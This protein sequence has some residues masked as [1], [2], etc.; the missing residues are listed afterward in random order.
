[1]AQI[2]FDT[3]VSS[4][5]KT[6]RVP[7]LI[8]VYV[9]LC[10]VL[11]FVVFSVLSIKKFQ[12]FNCDLDLGNQLQAFYNTL[13]GHFMEMT[14][15]GTGLNKCMWLG[16]VEII[17]LLFL[18]FFALFPSA[19]TLLIIQTIAIASGGL[20]VYALAKSLIKNRLTA[21]VLSLCYWFFPLLHTVN[22]TDF[23][24]DPF[25]ILPELL[26]WYFFRTNRNKAFWAAVAL[27]ICVKE[28]AFLFNFFLGI[29]LIKRNRK[30]AIILLILSLLQPLAI[31]P[32]IQIA[33]GAGRYKLTLE[34]HALG[35]PDT[36]SVIKIVKGYLICFFKNF[37]SRFGVLLSLILFLNITLIKFSGGI[38]FIVPLFI[39]L[40]AADSSFS[41]HRHAIIISPI[42]ITLIEGVNLLK[43]KNQ[44]RY[45]LFGALLP[46]I[47]LFLFWDQSI[48]SINIREM[49]KKTNRHVFHYQYTYHDKLADSLINMIPLD[50][51]AASD[52]HL[53]TKLVNRRYTYIHPYPEDKNI[54]DYFMFDFLEKLE[55]KDGFSARNR[56]ASLLNDKN[57]TLISYIDGIV[58]VKKDSL[59]QKKPFNFSYSDQISNT[60]TSD[61]TKDYYYKI[62]NS[63][64]TQHGNGYILKTSFVKGNKK[65]EGQ[66]AL[67]SFLIDEEKD[68]TIRILHLASYASSR[69]ENL[70]PDTYTEEFYFDI[71]K[72]STLKNRTHKIKLYS[73]EGYIPFFY[74]YHYDKGCIWSKT[75]N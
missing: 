63:T 43:S 74:K 72:G 68:D 66:N 31:T 61:F 64:I 48:I 7:D 44:L 13:K 34:A 75:L 15:N 50:T 47:I 4:L 3:N 37:P 10:C 51:K 28:H 55:Y 27:G 46:V 36:L 40:T 14:W 59:M 70:E 71:I 2:K 5:H 19:N 45:A 33:L 52:S 73:K 23:H 69:L 12:A 58:L 22:L 26:A 21:L 25:L 56:L 53:R 11:Y 41:T 1:M 8:T 67:I 17:Y 16:H 39:L 20:V 42:F 60:S 6:K 29:L 38:L 30:F 18:P 54:I 32:L 24:S 9:I 49:I 57:F 65:L 35:L 62:Q